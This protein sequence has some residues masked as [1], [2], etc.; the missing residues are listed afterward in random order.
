MQLQSRNVTAGGLYTASVTVKNVGAVSAGASRTALMLGTSHSVGRFS[1]F[2]REF[3]TPPLAP[4]ASYSREI[5]IRLPYH[6][7]GTHYIG[8]IADIGD[9]VDE[10]IEFGTRAVSRDIQPFNGAGAFIEYANPEYGDTRGPRTHGEAH[11]TG[12][13]TARIEITAPTRPN[14]GYLLVWSGN[15]PLF[16]HDGLT[17][18]AYGL[19]N[20]E[21]FSNWYGTVDGQGRGVANFRMPVGVNADITAWTHSMWID[22]QTNQFVGF[23]SN[24]IRTEIY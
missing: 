1:E 4:N 21:S 22:P 14:Y 3:A 23:G 11:F 19:L 6:S 8:A 2:L 9:S 15:S 12:S 18:V 5:L 20:T 16:I 7:H 24:T 17:G 13:G 10:S